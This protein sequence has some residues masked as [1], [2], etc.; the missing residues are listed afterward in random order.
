MKIVALERPSDY[1]KYYLLKE[2]G[3]Y[4][5]DLLFDHITPGKI[6]DGEIAKEKYTSKNKPDK[7]Y[8]LIKCDDGK[9]RNVVSIF[10][11]TLEECREK[12]LK[13]LGI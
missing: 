10:F 7:C 2:Y 12:K 9:W 4:Q 13:E 3:P 6:Y 1:E 5:I 11:I 8:Y